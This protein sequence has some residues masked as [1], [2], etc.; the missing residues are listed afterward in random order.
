MRL[1][2]ARRLRYLTWLAC[3]VCALVSGPFVRGAEGTVEG[4]ILQILATG[5]GR[6][7]GCM[8]ALDVEPAD[9]GLD[10]PGQWL[11]LD[12]VGEHA[13]KE[14]A[15]R[16]LE[17]LRAAVV[18]GKSVEMRVND[19]KKHGGYCFASRIK[20]QDETHEDGDSDGDGVLD[21]E[22]DLPLDA[23]DSVDTDDD[24][25]GN[26]ADNDDDND[27]VPDA[28]DA[29]PLD[30][31]ES[32]DTDGDGIGDNA[33]DDDDND[34]VSDAEDPCPL[35]K[36]DGCD[37][38]AP[39][40]LAPRNRSAFDARFVGQILSTESY[41]VEFEDGG[42]FREFARHRGDYVYSN[43]GPDTGK[44]TQTYDDS[45][46][47]GG[48]CEVVLTFVTETAGTSEYK[49]ADGE[50]GREDW[51]L[52]A[53][54]RGAFNIETEWVGPVHSDADVALR[55][56]VARW[57]RVV[58]GD[59]VELFVPG[60][61]ATV[62]D[63]FG[64]GDSEKVFGLVDDLRI[65][66]RVVE[67]DGPGGVLAGVGLALLRSTSRLPGVAVMD[68]DV[69][70]LRRLSRSA[71]RALMLHEM[72]HALG[73]GSIWSDLDLLEN[74]AYDEHGRPIADRPDTYFSGPKA[75]AAFD[76]ADGDDYDGE[77]VPVQNWGG[78]GS[79]DSHWRDSLFGVGEV[80]TAFTRPDGR[81]AMSLIT[82]E[83]MA[84]IGYEVDVSQAD[85]FRLPSRSSPAMRAITAGDVPRNWTPLNCRL[86]R[87][88]GGYQDRLIEVDLGRHP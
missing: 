42:R 88:I 18:A 48:S 70:D 79:A 16:M 76:A 3:V 32:V 85:D 61:T 40:G 43:T 65:Y 56:A 83:S 28:D 21:L 41:F 51:R 69:D 14:G 71:Q 2:N 35:D 64:N 22:D 58:S 29:F 19:E 17:S 73:F 52:D 39:E 72:A 75:V 34:G 78:P 7:G 55:A 13:E 63:L 80:M 53:L 66:V 24:G 68:L 11:T 60:G 74:P 87:P 67:I 12:C 10:C 23:S 47:Y 36:D 86:I 77:K 31:G 6:F 45:A 30:A 50:E 5:D 33:D 49:C 46:T 9:A 4:N 59:I 26:T 81:Q 27:G 25:V 1:T 62:D 54:E 82:V 20:I 84:D 57:E 38:A 8:I 44:V 15:V 37:E